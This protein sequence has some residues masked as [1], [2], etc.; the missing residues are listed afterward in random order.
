MRAT[1]NINQNGRIVIPHPVREGLGL[2]DGDLVE[3]DVQPVED[4]GL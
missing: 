4:G 3:I 1:V 2:K